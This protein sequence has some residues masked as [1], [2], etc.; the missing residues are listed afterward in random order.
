MRCSRSKPSDFSQQDLDILVPG[1]NVADRS[2]DFGRRDAGGCDLVQKRLEGVV[3]LAVE[4]RDLHRQ[5]GQRLGSF[6]AAKA[7][8]DDDDPRTCIL[9][10][11]HTL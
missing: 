9:I 7:A 11:G 4:Q 3:V 1:E 5:P 2:G 8:A 6:Q 10:H